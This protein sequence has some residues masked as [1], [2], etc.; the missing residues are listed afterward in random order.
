M[1]LNIDQLNVINALKDDKNVLLLGQAG[2]GK[3]RLISEIKNHIKDKSVFITSTTGISALNIGGI[4]LH[5]F[6]GIGIGNGTKEELYIKV[7]KNY[8]VKKTLMSNKILLIIDEVSMLPFELFEKIDYILKKI[9]NSSKA[10]GGIQILLSGD[11]LQLEPIND[12][13]IY[14]SDLLKQHFI[15]INLTINYRQNTDTLYQEILTNLRI[16]NLTGEHLSI[17]DKLNNLNI[18]EDSNDIKL[19]STNAAV[20]NLNNKY[21]KSNLNKEYVFTA[22]IKGQERQFLYDLEKQCKTKNIDTLVLKKDLKVML[23]K[24][25]DVSLGLVNGSLGIIE[26]FIGGLP[27]VKFN[28]GVTLLI[29]KATWDYEFN[30]KIVASITQIPL[31]IAYASTI[32][33]CQGLTLNTAIIDLKN[34]FA[35]HMIY[36]ALSRVKSL[37]GLKLL[38]FNSKKIQVNEETLNFYNSIK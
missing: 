33:K 35:P 6:L 2:T 37:K 7:C 25:I 22:K 28:N 15:I 11:F 16:N 3:S 26:E 34:I 31:V 10:F 14:K 19:F 38:N 4:T 1:A 18:E 32:H 12:E 21:L 13:P 20:N 23:V 5:S 36:V 30:G 8:K 29:D 17:L 27:K 24:N 9:R